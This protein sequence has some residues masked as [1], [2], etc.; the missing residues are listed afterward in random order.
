MLRIKDTL[1]AVKF[2]FILPLLIFSGCFYSVPLLNNPYDPLYSHKS[3]NYFS[4][5][6]TIV[7][8]NVNIN[9]E[10]AKA[11]Y[12]PEQSYG[13]NGVAIRILDPNNTSIDNTGIDIATNALI[14]SGALLDIAGD[15]I[16]IYVLSKENEDTYGGWGSHGSSGSLNIELFAGDHFKG[17]YSVQ[18][19][20]G[21]S[22]SGSFDVYI[23]N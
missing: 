10:N 4:M 1:R 6:G 8:K 2:T 22:V 20:D 14:T 7:N 17:T 13:D 5:N 16:D 18:E 23:S 3:K 9:I 11:F 21:T 12:A 15:N 19:E